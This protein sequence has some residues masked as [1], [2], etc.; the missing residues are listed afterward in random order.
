MSVQEIN[1]IKE[2]LRHQGRTN[3]WLALQ[4][5][6]TEVTISRWCQNTQ[7]PDLITL[8]KVAKLL[9]VSPK[10]LLVDKSND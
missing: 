8:F 9:G 1:R 2:V 6:K 4:L 10:E 7:Q 3:K 5:N